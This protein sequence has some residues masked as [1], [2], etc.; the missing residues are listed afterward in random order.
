MLVKVGFKIVDNN[1]L[2]FK[3]YVFFVGIKIADLTV[4]YL[5]NI[6]IQS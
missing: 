6:S 4:S 1:K 5:K 3:M 2:N